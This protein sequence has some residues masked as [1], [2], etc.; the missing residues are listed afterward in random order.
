ML[1]DA[2]TVEAEVSDALRTR[3]LK[4]KLNWL[5]DEAIAGEYGESKYEDGKTPPGG[6]ATRA[7]VVRDE[8]AYD[9]LNIPIRPAYIP[10]RAVPTSTRVRVPV[11]TAHD[12]DEL[13]ED[14]TGPSGFA[15]ARPGW[16]W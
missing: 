1:I 8:E 2:Y 7:T 16:S 3:E 14:R 9:D 5:L 4:D 10:P 12:L 11:E 13:A 6:F 15:P